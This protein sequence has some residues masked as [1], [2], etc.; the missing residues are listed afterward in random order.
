MKSDWDGGWLV[1]KRK[2]RRIRGILERGERMKLK[3]IGISTKR[4][5]TSTDG[6]RRRRVGD[7]DE[8]IDEDLSW[9]IL[10]RFELCISVRECVLLERWIDLR[11]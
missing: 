3:L 1:G 5:K 10:D 2:F 6:P 8:I 9:G 11:R 4:R 7:L